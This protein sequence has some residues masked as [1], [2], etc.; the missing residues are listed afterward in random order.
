MKKIFP[1]SYFFASL[2][3]SVLLHI[4]FPVIQIINQPITLL[5]WL[6][7]IAGSAINIWAD[8]LFKKNETTV[9]P[10]E[11]PIKL[12]DYGIFNFSR[13]PMY[14]GMAGILLGVGIFLG[15]M[16]SFAGAI[17]FVIAIAVYFI[18]DEEKTMREAFGEDYNN[19]KAKVR[20][21]I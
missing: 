1:P 3:T 15:S 20:R 12:I 17:L 13:N 19:Y 5:G 6:F 7:I 8:Q 9:K 4:L 11:K 16:T 2:I 18:P 21:W 10:D 14:L